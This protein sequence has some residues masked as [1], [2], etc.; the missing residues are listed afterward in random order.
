MRI[1]KAFIFGLLAALGALCVELIISNSYFILS[2]KNIESDYFNQ[3]TIFLIIVVLIEETFKYLVLVKLY[4]AP[5]GQP[6]TILPAIFTGL[7]FSL[8]EIFLLNQN[9]FSTIINFDAK[10]FGLILLHILTASLIGLLL[11]RK[12]TSITKIISLAAGLHLVYNLLVI[13]TL[14]YLLIYS[15]L[16]LISFLIII[17]NRKLLFQQN[18]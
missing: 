10:S 16:A 3:L 7:G 11:L 5:T 2:G 4:S 12:N 9:L 13:Y 18:F 8:V 15:Y 14:D 1:I 17:F 6:P